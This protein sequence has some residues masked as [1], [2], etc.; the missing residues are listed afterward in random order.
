MLANSR[1]NTTRP[2]LNSAFIAVVVLIFGAILAR[3]YSVQIKQGE[4]FARRSLGNFVQ[5]KRIKHSRGDIVDRRGNVLVT[6]RTSFD[7]VVTP[8]FLPNTRQNLMRL[9]RAAGLDQVEAKRIAVGFWKTLKERGPPVLLARELTAQQS[10]NVRSIQE[11][12]EIPLEAVPILESN[13]SAE[14]RAYDVY[15]DPEHLP[16]VTAVIR[17]LSNLLQYDEK[18]TKALM[19]NIQRRRGLSRYRDVVVRSDVSEELAARFTSKIEVGDLPGVSVRQSQTRYYKNGTMAAH[20][21]GYVNE[22]S[23]DEFEK[24]KEEGYFLGDVVG[25]R[26]I[27]STFESQLRGVDGLKTIVVDSKGRS[28]DSRFA[29]SLRHEVGVQVPAKSGRQ[30]VLSIDSELQK[31]AEDAFPGRAGA[32]VVM[33]PRNGQIL[34]MTSTPTYDPNLVSGTFDKVERKRLRSIRSLRPW[35]FRAIQEHYP[36]GSTFKPFTALAA[37]K[38]R[39]TYVSEKFR[40]NGVF[41]LG[42][43]KFR[44]WKHA[45]HGHVALV[46]SLAQSCDVYYYNLATRT[47]LD[48]IAEMAMDFGLGKRTGVDLPGEVPGIMPTEAWYNRKFREGYTGGA[49]VNVSIGQ[50]AVTIT[51][52]QLAVAY[53]ALV[54]GGKVLRPQLAL[55]IEDSDGLNPQQFE[56]E[57]VKTLSLS[58]R[59]L[60]AVRKGLNWVVNHKTGTAYRRR[61]IEPLVAGKTG[62]AQV[63]KL[64]AKRLKTEEMRWKVRDHAWF[65]A[66]AP[67]NDPEV[68]VIVLNEHGGHGGSAAAPTAMKVIDA[69]WKQKQMRVEHQNNPKNQ[70]KGKSG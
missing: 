41:R 8:A 32:V 2:I 51:P 20:L 12:L 57:I 17:R 27:E 43:T 63:A 23:P 16:S 9:S 37:L 5:T 30:I 14:F 53:S 67:V 10:R 61:L 40:C 62:T 15:L 1:K 21:L 54:N 64:G 18:Q 34:A 48:P 24:K 39:S 35:R 66:Y 60:K 55:R 56:P 42:D 68:V 38:K 52:L 6:N 11:V 25:R 49:A 65:A 31:I 59:S 28:Q 7:V 22:L 36:P 69:W 46:D 45:G 50:G 3:L 58:K 47:S 19:G 26:G 13:V 29:S 33:D 70:S 4:E 44:C